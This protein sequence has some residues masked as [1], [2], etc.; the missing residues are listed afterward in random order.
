MLRDSHGQSEGCLEFKDDCL[1]GM[2]ALRR[3]RLHNLHGPSVPSA[4]ACVASTLEDLYVMT[5]RLWL[6]GS[7]VNL[8]CSMPQ[9]KEIT[10]MLIHMSLWNED[11]DEHV[12]LHTDVDSIKKDATADAVQCGSVRSE[13]AC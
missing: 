10:V 5:C 9:L 1:A 2:T 3:L 12:L 11:D 8:L 7:H 6:E 4:L 13:V